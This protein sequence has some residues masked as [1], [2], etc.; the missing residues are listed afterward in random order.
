MQVNTVNHAKV[1]D[2]WL[3]KPNNIYNAFIL[4]DINKLN[5]LKIM[6]IK[7]I[8]LFIISILSDFYYILFKL[9]LVNSVGIIRI[10]DSIKN[11]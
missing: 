9:I 7:L 4:F 11:T 8:F 10:L 3:P 5:F 6:Y 1:L 2:N